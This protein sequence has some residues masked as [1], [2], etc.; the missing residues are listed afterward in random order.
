MGTNYY[1]RINICE[2]C[3]RYTE[4]HIGKSSVG[5]QFLFHG[6]NGQKKVP[7]I[8]SFKDW[9]YVLWKSL[10]TD[11]TGKIVDEY[12]REL[13]FDEFFALVKNNQTGSFND[14][15]NLNHYDHRKDFHKQHNWAVNI[16]NDW[17]DD[18]GY[19]FTS[20]EFS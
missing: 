12:G 6:Y 4:Q 14:R 20:V 8:K 18:E 15:L 9:L 5:W 13:S 16:N 19:S 7:E 17:K 3:N 2:H 1:H 11:K 10:T